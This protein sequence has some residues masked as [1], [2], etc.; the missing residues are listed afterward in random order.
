MSIR[1]AYIFALVSLDLKR[2]NLF[3]GD[4]AANYQKIMRKNTL[5]DGILNHG[6]IMSPFCLLRMM[7]SYILCCCEIKLIHL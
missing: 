4:Q 7:A 3:Y 2:E 5:K 1:I 6:L